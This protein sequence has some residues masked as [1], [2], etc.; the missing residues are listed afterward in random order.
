MGREAWA[1]PGCSWWMGGKVVCER[2]DEAGTGAGG[3]ARSGGEAI[4]RGGAGRS[5]GWCGD[6]P[7]SMEHGGGRGGQR[8]RTAGSNSLEER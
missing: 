7:G 3:G 5:A 1:S 6:L 2:A 4:R 8:V